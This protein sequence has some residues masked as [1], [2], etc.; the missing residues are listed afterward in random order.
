[1]NDPVITYRGAKAYLSEI[2]GQRVDQLQQQQA[3]RLVQ[4]RGT[5]GQAD[6]APHQKATRT[7]SY[8]GATAQMEV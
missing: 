2:T 1:M 4:Y 5:T 7:I 6:V 3:T 8:R